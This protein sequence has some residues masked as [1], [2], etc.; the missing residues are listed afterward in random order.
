MRQ[1]RVSSPDQGG[2]ISSPTR[3]FSLC[4]ALHSH[5]RPLTH[6]PSIDH[7]LHTT[8]VLVSQ[9]NG[10]KDGG[11]A[12]PIGSEPGPTFYLRHTLA[13]GSAALATSIPHPLL[14]QPAGG[15]RKQGGVVLF[16]TKTP[17]AGKSESKVKGFNSLYCW[18]RM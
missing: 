3:H 15:A 7:T 6:I 13:V 14:P 1:T 17:N 5:V 2:G 9:S 18:I 11:S 12:K 4:V 16:S 10:D 8:Q